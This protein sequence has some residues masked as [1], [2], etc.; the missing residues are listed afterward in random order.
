MFERVCVAIEDFS[1]IVHALSHDLTDFQ[2]NIISQPQPKSVLK[3]FDENTLEAILKYCDTDCLSPDEKQ[4]IENIRSQNAS[5]IKKFVE[6]LLEFMDYNWVIYTKIKHG[7][8]LFMPYQK[9][10]VNGMDTFAAPV[11]YNKKHPEQVKVLLLNPFIYSRLQVIFDSLLNLMHQFCSA[12][13]DYIRRGENGSFLPACYA[14]IT[15]E[16]EAH[17]EQLIKKYDSKGNFYNINAIIEGNIDNQLVNKIF[18]FYQK[19][20]LAFK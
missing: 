17:C 11:V 7:N 14:P 10:S 1:I 19:C 16:E 8:T 4:F 5:I 12:N 13:F 18:A 3:K 9:I 20:N 2:R 15:D 6:H